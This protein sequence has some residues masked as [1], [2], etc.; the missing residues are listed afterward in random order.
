MITIKIGFDIRLLATTII[1]ERTTPCQLAG[2]LV[3]EQP[4][5]PWWNLRRRWNNRQY[6]LVISRMLS[7]TIDY[8]MK[9]LDCELRTALAEWG[10]SLA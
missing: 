3:D 8:D 4:I 5:P 6:R 9:K 10:V 1:V 7:V 2:V